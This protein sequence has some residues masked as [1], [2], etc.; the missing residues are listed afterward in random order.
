MTAAAMRTAGP[1]TVVDL[2]ARANASRLSDRI[3]GKS[4]VVEFDDGHGRLR[5]KWRIV[6][7]D[8]S[9][10]VRQEATLEAGADDVPVR[11]VRLVD[12]TLPDARVVGT[13]KGSPIVAGTLFLGF[14]DPLASC[15][16][17]AGASALLD[18]AGAAAQG[19]TG[20]DVQLGRRRDR[21]RPASPRLPALRGARARASLSDV[22]PLQLVVRPRVLQQVR[23]GRRAAGGR[24]VRHRADAEARRADRFVSVRRRV[25]R[26]VH[27]VAVQLRVSGR[28]RE[29]ERRRRRLPRRPGGVDVAVGRVRQ[30]EAGARRGRDRARDTRS[31]MGASRCQVRSTTR[32]FA[33]PA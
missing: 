27:A 12:W 16:V 29:G 8:G 33:T 13:V 32:R 19:R 1:P 28:V 6:L 4:V 10:Y 7:R 24:R 2:P 17:A 23:R 14:E 5:V 22:P 25:G 20:R 31:R 30:A 26:S 21:G 18:G 3:P 15:A 11:E 9:N